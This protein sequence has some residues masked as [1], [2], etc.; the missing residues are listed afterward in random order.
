MWLAELAEEWIHAAA[1]ML[2]LRFVVIEE[3]E[4][5]ALYP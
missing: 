5:R 3:H 2:D 1:S 4:E